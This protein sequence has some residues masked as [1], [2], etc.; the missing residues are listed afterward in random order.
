ME[1]PDGEA[2]AL[3]YAQMKLEVTEFNKYLRVMKPIYRQELDAG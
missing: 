2:K 1:L 3:V